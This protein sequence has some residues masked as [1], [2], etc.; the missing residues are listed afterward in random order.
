M[1]T[2]GRRTAHPARTDLRLHRDPDGL[3]DVG[4]Q[5]G[6]RLTNAAAQLVELAAEAADPGEA[7]GAV[8][9]RV[10]GVD[11]RIGDAGVVDQLV[12]H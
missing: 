10:A 4:D 12:G 2:P 5:F 7:L 1:L 11:E 9:R 3:L 8:A 6:Q